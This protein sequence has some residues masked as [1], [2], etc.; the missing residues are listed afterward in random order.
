MRWLNALL[1]VAALS[2]AAPAISA[3]PSRF[4]RCDFPGGITASFEIDEVR[5]SVKDASSANLWFAVTE[6]NSTFIGLKTSNRFYG[7]NFLPR[8]GA[9]SEANVSLQRVTGQANVVLFRHAK[10]FGPNVCPSDGGWNCVKEGVGAVSLTGSCKA[11][12]RRF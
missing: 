7:F 10:D 2:V 12:A 3:E 9:I 6:F 4:I 5:K 1:S 8:A 11:S